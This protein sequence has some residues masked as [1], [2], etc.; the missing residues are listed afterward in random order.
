MN[1]LKFALRRLR[2]NPG[3]AALAVATLALGIGANTAVF[4]LVHALIVRPLPY[5]EPE[6]I[7]RITSVNPAA[8]V[9]DSL[10][11]TPNAADWRARSNLC[12]DLAVYQEWDGL[13]TLDGRSVL[14]HCVHAS[15]NYFAMLGVRPALGRMLEADDDAQTSGLLLPHGVWQRE[16]GGD[17]DIVGRSARFAG[18]P[19][20]VVGVLPPGVKAPGQT[21]HREQVFL[22]LDL[23]RYSF[24]RGYRAF[25][26]VARLR[27]DTTPA[28]AE[29]ELR[30]IAAGLAAEYPESNRGWDIRV[31][32]LQ[33][34]VT[35]PYRARLWLVYLATGIVLLIA[36]VNI[37]SLLLIRNAARRLELAIRSALGSSRWDL[38]R[39]PLNESLLLAVTGGIAGLLLAPWCHDALVRWAPVDPGGST[40]W[41]LNVPVLLST[42]AV[43][44]LAAL[45][46]GV[47]P[48]LLSRPAQLGRDLTGMTRSPTNSRGQQRWLDGLVIGQLAGS[49]VLLLAGGFALA[50]LSRTLQVDP[51]F[52][53]DNRAHIRLANQPEAPSETN[54]E[55]S[56]LTVPR[57]LDEIAA[58][59]GV[60]AV[61][62]ANHGLLHDPHAMSYRV[63]RDA[64]SEP[65]AGTTA[66]FKTVTGD[67][68]A[69]AGVP[70]L[71][72]RDFHDHDSRSGRQDLIVN[73]A[74]VRSLFPETDPI[75]RQIRLGKDGK[76]HT[77][78]GVVGSVRHRLTE[79]PVP[80][81]YR[82]VASIGTGQPDLMVHAAAPLATVLPEIVSTIRRVAPET[83]IGH[84]TTADEMLAE[85]L[86]APRFALRLI[87]VFALLGTSLAAL[88][89]YGIMTHAVQRRTREI[90]IHLALG[91]RLGTV[92]GQILRRGMGLTACGVVLG[93]PGGFMMNA[94]LQGMPLAAGNDRFIT[95]VCIA[96]LLAIVAFVACLIPA[97]HAGRIQPMEA[98]R[99]E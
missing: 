74:L 17:P 76:P 62:A 3:F 1:D 7:V 23:S 41:N 72:G 8:G 42:V 95:V 4:S 79:Q 53:P 39:L 78:I 20:V 51:G 73:A 30:Q 47:L 35:R 22:P 58:I 75:G 52:N 54:P 89:L 6:R 49:T 61:A 86:A 80:L 12:D 94:C 96:L 82:H 15:P 64:A 24:P 56:S 87:A 44:L 93:L 66:G 67:Y 9:T 46:A 27:P 60:T 14:L 48:A 71:A 70:L 26:V 5:S 59:P 99:Y 40:V 31:T 50:G 84:I 69:A 91:A 38:I 98:L 97:R 63:M 2:R 10:S 65:D 19:A 11:S 36:C 83:V 92:Q 37:S 77:I 43:S 32:R 68:F 13:L 81:I 34:W 28:Q 16:F 25:E 90:G 18:I 88:G 33:D 29:E 55:W 57:L 45:I 21:S 85:S